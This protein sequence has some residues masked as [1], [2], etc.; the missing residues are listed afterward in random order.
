MREDLD[1]RDYFLELGRRFLP[2]VKHQIE[3]RKLTFKFAKDWGVVMMCHGFIS[4]HILDDS[5]GLSHQRAGLQ[6]PN[7]KAHRKW[8]AHQLL[9]W[10]N[11]GSVRKRAEGKVEAKISAII[12]GRKFP[13]GFDR[14]WFASMLKAGALAHTYDQK[15]L[16]V[17]K[18]RELVLQPT[19]DIPPVD[20]SP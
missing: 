14:A 16:P 4:A 6:K 20:F 5:D 3:A 1:S 18:L 7:K 11:S 19:D 9:R 15:H 12:R 2:E 13:D 8:V 10:I 17:R